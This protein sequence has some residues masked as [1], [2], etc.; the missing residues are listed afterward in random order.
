MMK[1]SIAKKKAKPQASTMTDSR[2]ALYLRVSTD[3]QTDRKTI[4]A[5][6]DFLRNWA[7]LYD[8]PIAGIYADDGISGTIPLHERTDGAR[9]LQDAQAGCFGAVVVYRVDRLARSL[10]VLMDGHD[11]LESA[12]VAIKSA[13]E[14]F[15]SSTPIG[16][17][18][19]QLLGSMAELD[20]ST[21]IEQMNLG[22]DRVT[23]HGR[24]LNGPI[25]LGYTLDTADCLV[26]STRLVEQIGMTEAAMV[27]SPAEGTNGRADKCALRCLCV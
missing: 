19:F 21:L 1:K 16:K 15:D 2:I 8:F 4:D 7:N 24:W 12:G 27:L 6:L 10:R 11:A 14:P 9:L 26:P 22:R 5:Q 20:R 18:L 13:T 23:R 3:E 25:P 17:F